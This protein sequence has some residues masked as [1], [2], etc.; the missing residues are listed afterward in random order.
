MTYNFIYMYYLKEQDN[1]QA[2]QNRSRAAKD[3]ENQ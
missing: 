3:T 2:Y 1:E